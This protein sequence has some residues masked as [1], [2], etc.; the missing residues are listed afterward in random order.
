[1]VHPESGLRFPVNEPTSA[2]SQIQE[3]LDFNRG[4]GIQHIALHTNNIVRLIP[5][6]RQAGLSF[7]KVPASYYDRFQLNDYE[8]LISPREWQQ[9]CQQEILV[10][11]QAKHQQELANK[12]ILLQIFTQPIFGL[13]TFFFEFIERRNQAT[14][15]GEANFRALFLAIEQEQLKRQQVN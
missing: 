9:I 3:F 5:N 6:L 2:N 12:T 10:D 13:P 14:G 8:T 7:L 4:P 1:M 15:F 11:L